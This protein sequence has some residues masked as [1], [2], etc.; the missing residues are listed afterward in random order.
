MSAT[1]RFEET[2][3]SQCGKA[4]GPGDNGAS[5]CANHTPSRAMHLNALPRRRVLVDEKCWELAEHFLSDD[6]R[7]K[8]LN[9]TEYR[10]HVQGLAEE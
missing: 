5:H 4:L 6:P 10:M 9:P 8:N 7:V 3:C 2:F 1:P